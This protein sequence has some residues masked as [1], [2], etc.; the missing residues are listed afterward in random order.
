MRYKRT[1]Y[2]SLNNKDVNSIESP[3][4]DETRDSFGEIL[5]DFDIVRVTDLNLTYRQKY[6]LDLEKIYYSNFD[7]VLR[8]GMLVMIKDVVDGYAIYSRY[9][10]IPVRFLMANPL[11]GTIKKI[12]KIKF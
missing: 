7:A 1:F 11:A 9:V 8:N 6:E 4:Y 12:G 10:M 3:Y 2:T 5:E